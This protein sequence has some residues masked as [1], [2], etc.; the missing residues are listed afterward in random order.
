MLDLA[1]R[2]YKNIEKSFRISNYRYLFEKIDWND[3]LIGIKGG[4][5]VGKTTIM[6]QRA[7]FNLSNQSVLYMALDDPAFANLD[8]ID[9]ADI[10]SKNGIEYLF[11]DEVHRFPNWSQS[12]KS[13]Y[14]YYPD[15]KIVFTGSSVIE[16]AQA[17]S[18]LSRRAS[19]YQL[20]GLSFREYINLVTDLSLPA[21]PLQEILLNKSD[22][23]L[24]GY[25]P[26]AL[27]K[28]YLKYGYYPYFNDSS[29]S[30]YLDKLKETINLSIENDIPA[31]EEINIQ[32]IKKM[33]RF[34]AILAEN[35]PFKPN[36]SKLSELLNS[37]RESVI[38]YLQLLE[39]AGV[40]SLI[41]AST[42]G[43]R[44]LGK[45]EKILFDNSNIMYSLTANADKGTLRE[46]FFVNQ[47]KN[48]RYQIKAHPDADYLVDQ[49]YVFEIGG[50]NKT[51]SQISGLNNAFI[52]ADD[53]E[54]G[55]GNKIPLWHFGFLY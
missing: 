42:K 45:P 51:A 53:I 1:F 8:L 25:K 26:I 23:K 11:L 34:V 15:L 2:K 18:D 54:Y 31:V 10:V 19:M 21:I 50:K 33:R 7:K 49:Q 41:E 40:L 27:F 32:T 47:I 38:N 46:T 4:R 29:I 6:L 44:A 39:R 30:T 12:I 55:H 9:F 28:E 17:S 22:I 24:K 48:S 16:I 3:R 43:I 14:D 36:I 37:T 35:V 13:I 52:A 5:G 20:N